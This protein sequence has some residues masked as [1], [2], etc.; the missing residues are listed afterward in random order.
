MSTTQLARAPRR[1]GAASKFDG[2]V[3][4]WGDTKFGG[5]SSTVQERLAGGV[6][7]VTGSGGAFAAVK[8]DGSVIAWGCPRGRGDAST[9]GERLAKD[10]VR[11]TGNDG[12]FPAVK[13]DGSVIAWGDLPSA[14]ET[15]AR[16][17]RRSP[18]MWRA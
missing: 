18:K 16:L 12:A 4:T 6:R 10:V 14:A 7:R 1:V 17:G 5:D 8:S 2:S 13:S 11:A 9:V 15:P 3:V